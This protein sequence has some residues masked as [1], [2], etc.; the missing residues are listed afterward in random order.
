MGE[1][2]NTIRDEIAETRERMGD[3]SMRS[4]TRPT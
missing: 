1:D 4:A 2:P 3:T